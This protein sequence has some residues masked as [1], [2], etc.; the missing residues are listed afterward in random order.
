MAAVFETDGIFSQ[1]NELRMRPDVPLACVHAS[2]AER[3]DGDTFLRPR[4]S[5]ASLYCSL[6]TVHFL[7]E[8][9]R[10]S[11]KCKQRLLQCENCVSNDIMAEIV[12]AEVYP[13]FKEY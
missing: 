9:T 2:D 4:A 1:N 6:L 13:R 11:N 8:R 12:F 3:G 5:S 7:C 10:V